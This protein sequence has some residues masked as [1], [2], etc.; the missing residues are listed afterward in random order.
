[1]SK[2]WSP[3][4]R[5]FELASTLLS[6]AAGNKDRYLEGNSTFRGVGNTALR[7]LR[8]RLRRAALGRIPKLDLWRRKTGSGRVLPAGRRPKPPGINCLLELSD[9]R[10]V[11]TPA[12]PPYRLSVGSALSCSSCFARLFQADQSP[13]F[14]FQ[15]PPPNPR[16]PSQ[17]R[18]WVPSR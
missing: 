17:R 3:V 18:E 4:G 1:V 2:L 9:D 7:S 11:H 12:Q 13:K 15:K 8:G 10:C 6:L 14:K 16:R 5:L